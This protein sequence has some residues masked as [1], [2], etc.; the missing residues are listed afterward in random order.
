MDGYT[1][2]QM[3]EWEAEWV[4]GWI[5]EWLGKRQNHIGV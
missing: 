3:G 5:G 1:D 4:N 2:T